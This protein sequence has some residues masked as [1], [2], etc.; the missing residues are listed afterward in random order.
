MPYYL[1]WI[2]EQTNAVNLDFSSGNQEIAQLLLQGL[3]D[4][5]KRLIQLAACCR[6]FDKGIIWEI[7]ASQSVINFEDDIDSYSDAMQ[8]LQNRDF[9]EYVQGKYRL[10]DVARDVFRGELWRE[11][12]QLFQQLN[13]Q[14]AQYFQALAHSEVF[15]DSSPRQCYGNEQWCN[16]VAE[17]LY[18][19]FYGGK[20][21]ILGELIC[22]FLESFYF[23]QYEVSLLPIVF[24]KDEVNLEDNQSFLLLNL[25]KKELSIIFN[26]LVSDEPQKLWEYCYRLK[27]SLSDLAKLS[28]YLTQSAYA[29]PAHKLD[30][31]QQ[32]FQQAE[33]LQAVN[34]PEFLSDLYLWKIGDSFVELEAYENAIASFD[35]ALK[36][37]PDKDEAW[38]NRGIA[39]FNLGV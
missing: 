21:E 3:T 30:Y 37:K 8:W 29:L 15:A 36:I 11:D 9:V 25:L 5:Q 1:N 32:A 23:S 34:D 6:W 35:N 26:H 13:Q 10:D 17:G 2:R 14:L 4:I 38:Y 39:L 16:Y 22:R 12:R 19:G 28:L 7:L 27:S 33:T 31:L 24:I 20:Q 18:Y